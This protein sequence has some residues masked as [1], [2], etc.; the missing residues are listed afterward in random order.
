MTTTATAAYRVKRKPAEPP[1]P[2]HGLP[3][4][5]PKAATQARALPAL[6][7]TEVTGAQ[8]VHQLENAPATARHTG[9]GVVRHHDR[10]PRFLGEQLVDVAQQRAA[11]RE[12][13]ATLGD[14]RAQFRRS[15]LER[16]LHRA[17][18]VLQRL[19]QRLQNLV[20]I[21]REA[22]RHA[23][24]EVAALD[25]ELAHLLPGIGRADLDLD[26]LG[27]RLADEDA[28]VAAHVVHDRLVEA[29]AA[30]ACG[31]GVH[32]AIER[33]YGHL[34]GAAA[35]VEHHRAARLVHRQSRAH[36]RGH[37]LAHDRHVA[38]ARA[39]GRL[40]DGA[41]L[42]LRRTARH[43]HRHPWSGL[44][45]TVA[46]HLVDEVLQ[47]LLGVGEVGDHAVLH[48]THGRDVPGRAPEHGLGLGADRDDYLAA[49]PGLV[50]HRDHRGLVEHDALV[51]HIDQGVRRTQID[52]QIARKITAQAFEHA[53][54]GSERRERPKVARNLATDRTLSKA[55]CMILRW[56]SHFATR[57]ANLP[58]PSH[59]N[60]SRASPPWRGSI[61]PPPRSRC[62][63][64]ACR[65]SSTSSPP[66][67]APRPPTSPRCRIRLRACRS[68]CGRTW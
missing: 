42:H 63:R 43:A 25:R 33:Q 62:T 20:A 30:D 57:A 68:V 13:D 15:L 17:Y 31:V 54:T 23:F 10:E 27:G 53:A 65:G 56:F 52:R 50:L 7:K 51:A 66:W 9:Q 8:L 5:V 29:I 58:W 55:T 47:H 45:R 14:V 64:T 40:A 6:L 48:G 41:P 36:R 4:G 37:R 39:F 34:G 24:G 38:R 28:V 35:D 60:R 46:V 67:I 32:H 1:R 22:A 2:C 61:S 16:L 49:A 21:E 19:L 3:A 11:A 12:H 59:A 44:E 18:D 26:A